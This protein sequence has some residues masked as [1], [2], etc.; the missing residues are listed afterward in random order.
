MT[1]DPYKFCEKYQRLLGGKDWVSAAVGEGGG[2]LCVQG[3]KLWP[4]ASMAATLPACLQLV[5]L[6][7]ET[8]VNWRSLQIGC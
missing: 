6:S 4:S 3:L 7:V 1:F 2:A 8:L 5:V